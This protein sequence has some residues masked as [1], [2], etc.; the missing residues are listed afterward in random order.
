M[1]DCS[2]GDAYA[3]RQ[4]HREIAVR[5]AIGADGAAIVR[6]FVEQGV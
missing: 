4:R 3:V 1:L 5:M 6:L 2:A